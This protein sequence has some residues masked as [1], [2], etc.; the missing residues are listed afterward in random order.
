V[1]PSRR[2]FLKASAVLG[3]GLVLEFS[4]SAPAAAVS[5]SFEPNAFIRIDRSGT[6]TL[7]MPRVEMGQG[8]YTAIPQ[9]LAEELEVPLE[10]VRLEAAP[11]D[12]KKYGNPFLGGIQ[13]TGGS[14]A[15]RS[16]WQPLREAGAAARTM[17]VQAAARRWKVDAGGLVARDARVWQPS[18]DRSLGYGELVD[19]AATLPVPDKVQL[20]D[21][22]EHRLIGK[23]IRR[24]DAQGKVD[25]SAT[26][27]IDVKRPGMKIAT[28]AASPV[29]GGMLAAVDEAAAMKVLGVRQV[30]RL[31]NAVA[32]VADNM[33]AAKQGLAAAKPRWNDGPNASLDMRAIVA[34]LE[35]ESAKPGAVARSEGRAQELL[36]GAKRIEAVYQA[37]FLAH[38]TLEPPNCTVE[39]RPGEVDVWVGTQ[40]PDFAQA[41]AARVAAVPPASV[42]IHNHLIGGGF[43]RRL[44]V[45]FIEQA[46]LIGRQVRGPVKVIWSREE[47]IQHDMYRPYYYDRIAAAVDAS[48]MPIA[49]THR[50]AGSSIIARMLPPLFKNGLDTDAVEGAID[51][52]Y[53]LPAVHVDYVRVEP[54]GVPTAFWRG[55]GPTHNGFVVEGFIDELAAAAGRDPLEYRR[56]LIK[57]PRARNVLDLAARR[58]GWGKRLPRRE[59]RGIA[60]MHAFGSYVAQVAH[61][62]VGAEGEVRVRHVA[63]AIDCGVPVNPST[64]AAQ[65]EGGIV[66]GLTA[67]LWGQVTIAAGRVQQGNFGFHDYRLMRMNEAP[68]IDVDIVPSSAPLGGV[69]EPGTSV[70]IP[71]L[72]NAVYAATGRRIRTLPIGEQL[73]SR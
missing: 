71:A 19:L 63:C 14:T 16:S 28:V 68:R 72:V 1:N 61:V 51:A 22:A 3:G 64:I 42:R 23:P 40:V 53:A 52:P 47:D 2:S 67:G 33:W 31:E 41:A 54:P 60:L 44:E 65:M 25:G 34:Q 48:G 50:V 73:R 8:T 10:Q 35:R 69:G 24:L 13:M 58:A 70:A 39:V 20:K 59:G 30:V 38:A 43:G 36:A 27:G 5:A 15:I 56:A 55:V 17:L 66:F 6:I 9:L 57:E 11:A 4:L 49:W 45:D 46:V 29:F 12:A 21:P 26:F 62:A 37:P 7:V 32:V 18:K